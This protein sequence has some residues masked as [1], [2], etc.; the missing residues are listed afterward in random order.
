MYTLAQVCISADAAGLATLRTVVEQQSRAVGIATDAMYELIVA[1]NEL[2]TNIVMHGYR[3]VA[4]TIDVTIEQDGTMMRVRLC[5]QAPLFD[6]TQVPP[7]DTSLPPDQRVP[8]GIGIELARRTT[9]ALAY[10][11]TREGCN[12]LTLIKRHGDRQ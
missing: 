2:T 3:G 12:E 4:G 1:V 11:V 8:G 9:D 7:P 10:Q 5:D 6:P